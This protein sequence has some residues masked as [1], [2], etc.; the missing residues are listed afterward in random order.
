MKI[1]VWMIQ[2][3]FLTCKR[4]ERSNCPQKV[5]NITSHTQVNILEHQPLQSFFSDFNSRHGVE[6]VPVPSLSPCPLRNV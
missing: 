4:K 5:N 3:H 6:E 2:E 1:R